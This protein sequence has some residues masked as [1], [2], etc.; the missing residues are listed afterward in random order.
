MHK[1]VD[2]LHQHM[3]TQTDVGGANGPAMPGAAAMPALNFKCIRAQELRDEKAYGLILLHCENETV[4]ELIRERKLVLLAVGAAGGGAGAPLAP[5]WVHG[6]WAWMDLNLGQAAQI[7]PRSKRQYQM[8][9]Y[10]NLRSGY[11]QGYNA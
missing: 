1:V 10:H 9:Q 8:D 11:H 6:L 7:W 2:N 3:V 4:K 5:G